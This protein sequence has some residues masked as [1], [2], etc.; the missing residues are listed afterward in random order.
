ML[1]YDD[2]TMDP[3]E[4]LTFSDIKDM[5]MVGRV[6]GMKMSTQHGILVHLMW[7]NRKINLVQ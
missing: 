5:G 2:D 6:L 4:D 1:V 3:V 7:F